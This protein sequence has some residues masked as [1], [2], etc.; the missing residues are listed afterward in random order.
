MIHNRE[1][2]VRENSAPA[3]TFDL[4]KEAYFV[5]TP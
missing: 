3:L 2:T 1:I 5:I 4:E